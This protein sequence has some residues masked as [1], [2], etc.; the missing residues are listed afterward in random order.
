LFSPTKLRNFSFPGCLLVVTEEKRR[1]RRS[2][3]VRV[4]DENHHVPFPLVNLPPL[5][6]RTEYDDRGEKEREGELGFHDET[7]GHREYDRGGFSIDCCRWHRENRK[8]SKQRILRI[9]TK[10]INSALSYHR[11]REELRCPEAEPSHRIGRL[12]YPGLPPWLNTTVFSK[13]QPPTMNNKNGLQTRDVASQ[14][15]SA[16][17]ERRSVGMNV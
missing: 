1:I 13:Q 14:R 8:Y 4:L 11:C 12:A 17:R 10:I 3:L 5:P 9:N 7:K 6:Q 15:W 16:E 2:I